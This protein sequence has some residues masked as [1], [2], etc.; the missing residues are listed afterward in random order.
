VPF[1]SNIPFLGRLF[2]RN[3]S[4]DEDAKLFMLLNAE[5]MDLKEKEAEQ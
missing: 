2:T 1:L 4:Y 3:G 5:I